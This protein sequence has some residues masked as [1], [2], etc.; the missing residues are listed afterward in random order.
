MKILTIGAKPLRLQGT[1]KQI[2]Y[3]MMKKDFLTTTKTDYMTEVQERVAF[4]EGYK[5][6]F[7]RGDHKGFLEELKKAGLI[8]IT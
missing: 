6:K 3:K 2:V 4:V 7:D 8:K 5:M 1:P